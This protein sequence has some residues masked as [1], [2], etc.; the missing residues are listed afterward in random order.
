MIIIRSFDI[1]K[2]GEIVDNLKGGVAGGTLVH[3]VLRLGQEIEIRPGRVYTD[4]QGRVQC[5]PYR[6]RIVSLNADKNQLKFAIP[7]G[8]IGVGTN[9]E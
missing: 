7:G 6:S 3:G 4:V 8:L 2:P 9:L 5:E 1:N